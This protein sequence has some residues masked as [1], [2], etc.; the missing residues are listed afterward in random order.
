MRIALIGGTGN[1]GEGLALRL[2]DAHEIVVGSRYEDKAEER[3]AEYRQHLEEE[4]VEVV[5]VEGMVNPDAAESADVVVL[6]LPYEYLRDALE[7]LVPRLEDQVVVSPVVPMA[8]EGGEFVYAGSGESAAEEVRGL[9]PESCPVVSAFHTL[10][11]VRLREVSRDIS[12]DV[13]VS[14]DDEDAKETVFGLVR[15]MDDLTPWDGGS[16]RS[17][18]LVES[19]TPLLLNLGSINSRSN[20]GV[21]FV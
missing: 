7:E 4:G 21:R 20:L 6:T 11:A 12:L 9:V 1:I 2:G 5:A 17:S 19:L 10:S 18:R 8:R 15:E 13:V 16:L 14:G 3:A